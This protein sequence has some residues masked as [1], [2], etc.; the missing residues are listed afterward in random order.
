VGILQITNGS[1]G[2]SRVV[3]ALFSDLKGKYVFNYLDDLVIYSP[4]ESLHKEHLKE[5]LNRLRQAGFTLNKEKV[6]LGVEEIKYLGHILSPQGIRVIP[7]RVEA[8]VRYPRPRNL[9][10]LR[11]FLGVVGFYGRFIEEFSN[12]AAPLHKLKGKGVKFMWGEEHQKAFEELKTALC[13]A[14]VLQVP[15]FEREFV[16]AT[17]ASNLAISAVLNQRVEGKLA[18]VAYYSR[19]LNHTERKYSTYEKEC[20]AVL[21]GCEKA[22]CYLEH[23]EFELHCDNLALCWLFRNVKDVGRLGRWILRLAPFK[24]QVH[25]TRG[26]ENI[27]PDAL[28]R[29]F[30][31][32][33]GTCQEEAVIASVQGLPLVY[34]SL[35]SSQK[36]DDQCKEI[37]A[38]I[39]RGDPVMN[40]FT[41]HSKLICYHPRRVGKRR[42]VVPKQLQPMV[43]K[44]YHDSPLAGHLGMFKTWHKVAKNFY[45]STLKDDVFQHVRQCELCQRAKPA[46]NTKEGLHTSSPVEG[47]LDRVFIDF[48]GPM[49]RTKKGNQAI[50]VVMDGFSKFVSFFPVRGITSEVV[51]DRLENQYFKAYG[52]PRSLVTDNARVFKSKMFHDFC[53][54]WGIKRIHTT[55]YY[56]KGSLA[57]RVMRNLK[58]A[59]QIFHHDS[60]KGWDEDL[61]LL[62]LAF[63][64]AFHESSKTSPSSLFLGRELN[65]PLENVWELGEVNG[66]KDESERTRFWRRALQNLTQARDRVARRYNKGRREASYKVGDIVIYRKH[67][68]SSKA[69]GISQK[70]AL[71][72]SKPMVILRF[73]APNVVQLAL[74]ENRAVTRKAH[75]TQIKKFHV[76]D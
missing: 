19:L 31:E 53:F 42:Y 61:H 17:D 8:V 59:L 36:E 16:L 71:R 4:T 51:C 69:Q 67:V 2:L 9:R 30:E 15:D 14:P 39:E 43:I 49:T 5:V 28:S 50:L 10:G 25:H 70:L 29:M 11:R 65:T 38:G 40:K 27:V 58:A 33:V 52:I 26:K 62:T 22:R 7:E 45:W 24:F 57:E 72:W 47:V 64:S 6:I 66:A 74:V 35:E 60:Q 18:P 41:V 32:Q 73:T 23:K 37:R 56:P 12:K 13:E 68:M 1:Q 75:L 63:N 48:F 54:K 76:M 21:L 44:Y 20:L 46:Q 3:D 34:M 55:P